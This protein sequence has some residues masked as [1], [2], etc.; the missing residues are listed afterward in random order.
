MYE[1]ITRKEKLKGED[2]KERKMAKSGKLWLHKHN[3]SAQEPDK[4][5]PSITRWG[6]DLIDIISDLTAK[7][8]RLEMTQDELAKKMGVSQPVVARFENMGRI[9]SI[10]FIY[11]VADG[12]GVELKPLRM[13]SPKLATDSEDDE[14]DMPKPDIPRWQQNIYEIIADLT[15]CRLRQRISQAELARRMGTS[16]SVITRFERMGRMPTLEFIYRVADALG[17]ELEPIQILP[18]LTYIGF[19]NMRKVQKT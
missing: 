19:L 15:V 8:T 14:L 4:D 11:K 13:I 1:P 7:R 5:F 2:Y 16:Q 12:L 10:E 17:A 9:P 18:E 6:R 3:E